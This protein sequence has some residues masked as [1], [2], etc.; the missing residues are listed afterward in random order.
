M[1]TKL[2]NKRRTKEKNLIS[3]SDVLPLCVSDLSQQYQS[4]IISEGRSDTDPEYPEDGVDSDDKDNG[5]NQVTVQNLLE[6]LR[7]ND[8]SKGDSRVLGDMVNL[9]ITQNS[10]AML[11]LFIW[12]FFF[13]FKD[14][15]LDMALMA[16]HMGFNSDKTAADICRQFQV[17]RQYGSKRSEMIREFIESSGMLMDPDQTKEDFYDAQMDNI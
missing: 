3:P 15:S 6:W 13:I 5:C 2:L 4:K 17:S 11:K 8:F 14:M 12:K 9:C 7:L 10:R 1:S 16:K